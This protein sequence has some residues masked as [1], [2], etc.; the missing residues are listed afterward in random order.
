MVIINIHPLHPNCNQEARMVENRVKKEIIKV[1]KD[2]V[3][4]PVYID[5]CHQL[6]INTQNTIGVTWKD[7]VYI[8]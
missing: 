6:L 7:W 5:V 4:M 2:I 3:N 1:I 8:E